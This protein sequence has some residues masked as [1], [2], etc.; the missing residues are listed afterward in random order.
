MNE[1]DLEIKN[2]N[3]SDLQY[4]LLDMLKWFHSFCSENNLRYYIV[5]GTVIGAIRH[6]G[7]I[8]WDDDIDVGM[9]RSDYN[10][11]MTIMT[12]QDRY[13]LE[14]PYSTNINYRYP[15]CKLFDSTTKKKKKMR[16]KDRLGVYI[17]IFPLDGLGNTLE[18]SNRTFRRIDLLNMLWAT[19]VCALRKNRGVLKNA[20]IILSRCIPNA[21]L[22]DKRLTRT[23]DQICGKRDFDKDKYVACTLSTYRNKEIMER[24][25]YGK[26]TKY[27][28]EGITVY[29]PE[30]YDEYLRKI[31]GKWWELPPEE[32]RINQHDYIYLNLNKSYLEE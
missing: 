24:N 31:Y 11:L 13:V 6:R 16:K 23:I 5:E 27:S 15:W 9:P 20:A 10:R 3:L 2:N 25:I 4:L 18:E 28:F 26:P 14:T 21:I 7:F 8:P 12:K 1:S 17:D 22:N 32:K 30:K 19:R 29:G